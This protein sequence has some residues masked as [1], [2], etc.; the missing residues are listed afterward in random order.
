PLQAPQFAGDLSGRFGLR[1]S[2]AR[3][4]PSPPRRSLEGSSPAGSP[5]V[6]ERPWVERRGRQNQWWSRWHFSWH[7]EYHGL[8]SHGP[9]GQVLTWLGPP[10]PARGAGRLEWITGLRVPLL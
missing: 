7:Q 5:P 2:P 6:R 8:Q 3:F 4:R 1:A 9:G 10:C